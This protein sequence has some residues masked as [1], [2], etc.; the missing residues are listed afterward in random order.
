M[1]IKTEFSEQEWFN[2]KTDPVTI[3]FLENL[4][5]ER[6]AIISIITSLCEDRTI[7]RD[8]FTLKGELEKL[9]EIIGI[10]SLKKFI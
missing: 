10:I 4:T 9:D 5:I 2:W 1:Q 8:Y 3:N 6:E 7:K